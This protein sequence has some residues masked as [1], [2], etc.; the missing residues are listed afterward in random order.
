MGI[1]KDT[2]YH[3]RLERE[4][5]SLR[6]DLILADTEVTQLK[7]D[8]RR[9][10]QKCMAQTLEN[11]RLQDKIDHVTNINRD[12]MET[13]TQLRQAIAVLNDEPVNSL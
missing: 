2:D 1:N 13:N 7:F 9:A 5:T 10:N 4:I 12:L 11:N 8:L 6:K 3:D